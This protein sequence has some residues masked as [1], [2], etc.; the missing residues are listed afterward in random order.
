MKK[1]LSMLIMLTCFISCDNLGKTH[2]TDLDFRKDH[3]NEYAYKKDG[4]VFSGTAWSSDGKTVKI[5]VSNGVITKVTVYHS[6]GNV[7]GTSQPGTRGSDTFFDTNGNSITE[8]QFMQ[9]YPNIMAQLGA[10]EHEV[11]YIEK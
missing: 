7:A 1:L 2:F 3:G 8:Q 4:T 9:L 5:D 10:L 11:H 6:N